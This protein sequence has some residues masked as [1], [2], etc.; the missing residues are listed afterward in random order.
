M[1]IER[2]I[3][4]FLTLAEDSIHAALARIRGNKSRFVLAVDDAGNLEG[5]LTDGDFREWVIETDQIDLSQPVSAIFNVKPKTAAIDDDHANIDALFND[6]VQWI[7]LLDHNG[8]VVAIAFSHSDRVVIGDAEI[9]EDSPAF[10]IAEIGYNHQ[11]RLDLARELVDEAIKA[12]ADCVKFQLR[13]LE[14]LYRNSGDPKDGRED[15]AAQYVLD[16]LVRFQLSQED[17]AEIFTYSRQRGILPL[18]SPWDLSSLQ[19]LESQGMVAYKIASADL[20]NHDLIR[21]AAATTK[22]LL[23]STGMSTE[24]EIRESLNVVRDSGTPFILLH[25][26]STYPTPFKDVNLRYMERL[27]DIGQC[28]VG[29]SGHER[30]YYIALAATARGAKV[31]EKHFTLDRSMEGNDHKVSLLPHEFREMVDAIRDIE[32]ALGDRSERQMSQ[33]E[34]INREN[35][36]KSLVAAKPIPAGSVISDEMLVVKSPGRGLQ[37]NR[38]SFIIG[39][40]VNRDLDVGDFIYA[41]DVAD[42][43]SGPRSF[44][45]RRPWGIPVRYHDFA[46]LLQAA[47]MD[48]AEFHFSFRDLEEDT[49]A[50]FSQPYDMDLV[51]HAPEIFAGSYLLNLASDDQSDI[52]RGVRELQRVVDVTRRMKPFFLRAAKPLIVTNMG[53]FSSKGFID[54]SERQALYQRVADSLDRVDAEGVEIIAQ[55]MPPFPWLF[56]GQQFHNL[57]LDPEDTVERVRL[58]V[59]H[60]VSLGKI[61]RGCLGR[62]VPCE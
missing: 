18:C 4:K 62:P 22:P 39:K 52:D 24:A 56:G 19:F 43:Q 14:T 17:L 44:S 6:E 36:A 61:P 28:P 26:N 16:Q 45:F 59:E 37:P 7:P 40:T 29:Y 35:L 34:I 42:Q 33:G 9:S 20:T 3:R 55:T 51:V 13:D 50:H 60:A 46:T 57:F 8:H 2:N 49:E 27:K 41:S 25:C 32:S 1:I 48:L 31:I 38:R 58:V 21:A 5:V 47:P 12:K 53:G 10:I 54:P 30:H 11:G 23:I 15:L